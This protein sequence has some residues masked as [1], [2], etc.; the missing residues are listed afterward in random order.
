M[1]D[2][3]WAKGFI[4]ARSWA[5][6]LD[7]RTDDPQ[8]GV[9]IVSLRVYGADG[10]LVAQTSGHG[11]GVAEATDSAYFYLKFLRAFRVKSGSDKD[12][13]DARPGGC[14]ITIRSSTGERFRAT[15]PAEGR[16]KGPAVSHIKRRIAELASDPYEINRMYSEVLQRQHEH[17]SGAAQFAVEEV[18][19]FI[20][21]KRRDDPSFFD[22]PGNPE[23]DIY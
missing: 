10:V 16:N 21:R 2:V 15:L 18:K 22:V 23:L 12:D 7:V 13:S 1:A 6:Q 19:D 9:Y 17:P 3:A 20:D 11:P 8:H 14:A 5:A 4:A